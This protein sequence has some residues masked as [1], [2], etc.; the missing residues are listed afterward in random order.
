LLSRD[1]F[2][3]FFKQYDP[4]LYIGAVTNLIDKFNYDFRHPGMISL[5]EAAEYYS[6]YKNTI[7]YLFDIKYEILRDVNM[8]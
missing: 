3:E 6:A 5:P 8:C 4:D 2:Y 1:E 7:Q